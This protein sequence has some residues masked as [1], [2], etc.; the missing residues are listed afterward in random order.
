MVGEPLA[1]RDRVDH[2]ARGGWGRDPDGHQLLSD[3]TDG[4]VLKMSC[5]QD[6]WISSNQRRAG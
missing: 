2:G 6:T 5:W 1:E 3:T 4:L